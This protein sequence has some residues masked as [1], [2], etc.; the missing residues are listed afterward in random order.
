MS[1][2]HVEII[3]NGNGPSIAELDLPSIPD[4]WDFM[5]RQNDLVLE[6]NLIPLSVS[7]VGDNSASIEILISVPMSEAA[8]ELHEITIEVTP[9]G[10]DSDMSDNSITHMM[11]TG[12][13]RYPSYNSSSKD[14]HAMIDSPVTISGMITN[15]GNA[16]ES[17]MEIGCLLYTSPSPRD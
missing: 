11:M 5:L 6:D 4:S 8:G 1:S 13:I 12:S 7:Y 17:D 9:N 10:L 3:N 2:I 14:I 16:L 15:V